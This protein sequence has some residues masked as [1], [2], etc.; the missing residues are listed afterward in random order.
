M[1]GQSKGVGDGQFAAHAFHSAAEGFAV[2]KLHHD[3]GGPVGLLAEFGDLDNARVI[4]DVDGPRFVEETL[5][6]LLVYGVL[7]VQDFDRDATLDLRIDGLENRA[8]PPFSDL[9]NDVIGADSLSGHAF[10]PM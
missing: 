9:A 1:S 7:G 10:H 2:E 3:V 4:D 5:D 6:D 8:H